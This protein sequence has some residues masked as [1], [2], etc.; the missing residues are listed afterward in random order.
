MDIFGA[1]M[2]YSIGFLKIATKSILFRNPHYEIKYFTINANCCAI[3]KFIRLKRRHDHFDIFVGF[4]V[5]NF[6]Q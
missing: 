4:S 6:Q 3:V 2:I 1:I 5:K